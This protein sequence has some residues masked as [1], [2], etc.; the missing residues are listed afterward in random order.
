MSERLSLF[1]DPA[2]D[3]PEVDEHPALRRN[4]RRKAL[5]ISLAALLVLVLVAGATAMWYV[6]R[7]DSALSD[8]KREEFMPGEGTGPNV[9]P[10]RKGVNFVL[11]GTD[12]QP[13]DAGRSDSLMIAHVT[14]NRDKVYLISLPRD[15]WVDIPGR[16]K[17]KINWAYAFGGPELT[18][19][20]L[21]QLLGVRIDHAAVVDFEGFIRLT[22]AMDGVEVFN[23]R[24]FRSGHNGQYYPAGM[25]TLKGDSALG[26]VRERYNLPNGDLDRAENQRDVVRAILDKAAR[27]AVLSNPAAVDGI[28]TQLSGALTVDKALTNEKIRET[29]LSM[30]VRSGSDIVNFQAPMTGFGWAGD[31]AI[32]IVDTEQMAEL[33]VAL[34]D[35]HLDEYLAKFPDS[36]TGPTC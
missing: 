35:D 11:M 10:T 14:E 2:A 15:L 23:K 16:G 9:L 13:G 24:G 8:I 33:G 7:I 5:I 36:C 18:I 1:D 4:T 34:R 22:E 30:R 26:Y 31:Q 19:R 28:L 29:A 20:T 6:Q 3:E 32:A 17:G 21:D 25:V 12:S 27:P